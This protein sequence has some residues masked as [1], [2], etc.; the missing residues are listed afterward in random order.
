MT[1]QPARNPRT[2]DEA[3]ALVAHVESLF[4]PW[5]VPAL[6]AGFTEDCQ[7]GLARWQDRHVGGRVQR[8]R[9]RQ[10][11]RYGI[12][13]ILGDRAWG[14]AYHAHARFLGPYGHRILH[15]RRSG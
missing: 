7:L 10:A 6:V 14:V 13:V 12:V 1:S 8:Q 9:D 3:R 11:Q 5:N 4:M 15:R 2:L